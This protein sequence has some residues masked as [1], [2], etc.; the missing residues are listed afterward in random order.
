MNKYSFITPQEFRSLLYYQGAVQNIELKAEDARLEEFYQIN[1]AY[2][3]INMLLF[4]GIENEK[5]RLYVEKRQIDEAIFDNIE[6][7]LN[8]YCWLYSAMCKYMIYTTDGK[9]MH[10]R[11]DDRRHT[12]LCMQSGEN[13]SFLST[14][15]NIQSTE[16][17]QKK[18]GLVLMEFLAEDTVEHINMND[19]LGSKSAYPNENE[20]LYSPFLYL[21]ID[22]LLLNEDEKTF[23][24]YHQVPPYGKY[25]ITLKGSTI[26][27]KK[28]TKED[29]DWLIIQ[30]KRLI[31]TQEIENIK[32]VWNAIRT[33]TEDVYQ[34]E[35]DQYIVWKQNLRV[36]LR[37][38]YSVIK[39]EQKT[40]WENKRA[41]MFIKDLTSR[42]NY[43]NVKR[44]EYE[45][46]LQKYANKEI[47]IG[48]SVGFLVSLILM[49][50]NYIALRILVAFLVSVFGI[51]KLKCATKSLKQKLLQRTSAYLKYDELLND[52]NYEINKTEK[53][54]EKYI[55]RMRE[56]EK[57]DNQSC[58]EYTGQMVQGVSGF[59]EKTEKM[60]D[61]IK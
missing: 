7:L 53:V 33:N 36:Y 18:D 28:P 20:I 8:T 48:V 27:P 58:E 29:K 25:L 61:Q 57:I 4:P 16:Y 55:T 49:G 26:N 35:I 39:Y 32:K 42:R 59:E 1:N 41:G 56:I 50:I 54:L 34:N 9:K 13:D 19:V 38:M 21:T 2:E 37:E 47:Y 44:E 3:T 45:S 11:R 30:R 12:Y 52:W 43:S 51:V 10:T 31:A 6:E 40:L 60:T 14:S 15:L 23:Q 24:D 17:F 22:P 5:A 46:E